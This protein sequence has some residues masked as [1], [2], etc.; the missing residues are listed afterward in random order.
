MTAFP[1]A[2]AA[3]TYAALAADTDTLSSELSG[4]LS[5][6]DGMSGLAIDAHMSRIQHHIDRTASLA[7]SMSET[8]QVCSRQDTYDQAL[9]EAPTPEQCDAAHN[10]AVSTYAQYH[11]GAA[12][13][14][15]AIAAQRFA[16]DLAEARE[17][18]VKEHAKC[19]SGTTFPVPEGGWETGGCSPA[20]GPSGT[21][22]DPWGEG[23]DAGWNGEDKEAHKEAEPE[24]P[25]PPPSD[26]LRRL[27][28]IEH[29]PA[30][31]TPQG[32][33]P[34]PEQPAI[35]G[36]ELSSSATPSA[37]SSV[38]P[39]GVYTPSPQVP[40]SQN[41]A[42]TPSPQWMQPAQP[43]QPTQ[44]QAQR[45]YPASASSK[46]REEERRREKEAEKWFTR[47]EPAAAAIMT[48][49]THSITSTP[50]SA[51]SAAPPAPPATGGQALG[52]TPAS[53]PPPPVAP[54]S[55]IGSGAKTAAT[56]G[57]MARRVPEPIPVADV[58]GVRNFLSPQQVEELERAFG[59]KLIDPDPP[60]APAPADTTPG[61]R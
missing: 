59:A 40:V 47:G 32:Y 9:S 6:L 21:D 37:L 15:Q 56:G 5:M 42:T 13:L 11:Q 23:D 55:T 54:G 52:A 33:A 51:P 18:A 14:D 48:T 26:G 22:D 3:T 10:L 31:V 12:T 4:A 57:G 39:S 49:T 16:T 24:T 7:L 1:F 8:A 50:T 34:A 44:T 25:T 38:Q 45:P 35:G 29:D 36:T 28:L 58:S 53:Q 20:D 46:Q 17:Q 19:T 43:I 27:P 2:R 41:S 61:T 60:A 30:P